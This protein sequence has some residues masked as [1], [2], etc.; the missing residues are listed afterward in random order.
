[1]CLLLDWHISFYSSSKEDKIKRQIVNTE[2]IINIFLKD[3]PSPILVAL[4]LFGLIAIF[5]QMKPG[6]IQGII[7]TNPK[8]PGK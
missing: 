4:L 3:D 6:L 8:C 2:V 1:M 7:R 5:F